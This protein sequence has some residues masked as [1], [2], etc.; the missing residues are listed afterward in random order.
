M[1]SSHLVSGRVQVGEGRVEQVVLQGVEARWDAELPR[2]R[3]VQ[4][5]VSGQAGET[6]AEACE[7]CERE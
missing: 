2:L 5:D 3:R 4:Q 7:M 6:S 1:F